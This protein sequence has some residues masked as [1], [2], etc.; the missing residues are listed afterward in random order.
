M[1]TTKALSSRSFKA[2][3]EYVSQNSKT[4]A[5]LMSGINCSNSCE[6]AITQWQVMKKIYKKTTGRSCK[7]YVHS[8]AP[9]EQITPEQAHKIACELVARCPQFKGFQVFIATHTDKPHKHSHIVIN[10]VSIDDGHKIQLT[11]SDL[12]QIKAINDEICKEH[13]LSVTQKGQTFSKYKRE[14][15][16]TAKTETYRLLE[17]A[18]ES[19]ADSWMFDTAVKILEIKK[20]AISKEDFCQQLNTVGVMVTWS[21]TRRNITFQQLDGIGKKGK[22]AKKIRDK[23]LTDIFKVDISKDVL[24]H[25]FEQNSRRE[26]TKQ[27]ARQLL[28]G[29]IDNSL[30]PDQSEKQQPA[31]SITGKTAGT[32]QLEAGVSASLQEDRSLEQLRLG[33][34]KSGA[35][36]AERQRRL[37][38]QQAAAD[39]AREL[40]AE[41]QAEERRLADQRAAAAQA[42]AAAQRSRKKSRSDDWSL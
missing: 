41:K 14:D 17:K 21:E 31:A 27:T 8:F 34:E 40:E 11:K 22:A 18:A 20:K 1:A 37:R 25:E 39:K 36:Q 29:R 16:S 2:T 4:K 23:T 24:E 33:A 6:T 38:E 26:R 7:H 12:A 3:L 5:S 30:G 42:A 9:E 10:S 32:Q 19:K 28:D 13:G 35:A 15:M